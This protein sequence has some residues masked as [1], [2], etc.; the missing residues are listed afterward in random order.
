M[1]HIE[2]EGDVVDRHVLQIE[3][4]WKKCSEPDAASY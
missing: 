3:I 2:N 4:D 1:R